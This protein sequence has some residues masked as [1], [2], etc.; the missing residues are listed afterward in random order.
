MSWNEVRYVPYNVINHDP[1]VLFARMLFDLLYGNHRVCHFGGQ[2]L[3]KGIYS[4]KPYERFGGFTVARLYGGRR[5]RA[6]FS[7]GYL[8]ARLRRE[9]RRIAEPPR[10]SIDAATETFRTL[11]CCRDQQRTIKRQVIR[12]PRI[13]LRSDIR[14]E[15]LMRST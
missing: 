13:S 8:P 6:S 3:V 9:V 1:A 11:G 5:G 7:R 12:M 14:P 15:Y 2:L 4:D 10:R